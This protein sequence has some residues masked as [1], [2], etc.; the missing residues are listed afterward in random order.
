M[1]SKLN[2]KFKKLEKKHQIIFTIII[3]SGLIFFWRGI[4]TI[5]DIFS[6][7]II[8]ENSLLGA[9]ISIIIGLIILVSSGMVVNELI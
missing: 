1:F 3:S 7:I 2:E 5:A 9:I 6:E 4:W 8:P